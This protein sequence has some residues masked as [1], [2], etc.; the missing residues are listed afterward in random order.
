MSYVLWR[1]LL[2]ILTYFIA[3]VIFTL[4]HTP[5]LFFLDTV[6]QIASANFFMK[7]WFH[8]R[9]TERFAWFINNL[10][11]P[12]LQDFL[13]SW[14]TSLVWSDPILW[15]KW[16]ATI[17]LV[18]YL[19]TLFAFYKHFDL[20]GKII[21]T[22]FIGLFFFIQKPTLTYFQWLGYVDFITTGLLS[23]FLGAIRFLRLVYELLGKKRRRWISILLTLC[24]LSHL[25]MAPVA[26][27][28]IIVYTLLQK[29]RKLGVSL[30]IAVGVTSFFWLPLFFYREYLTSSNV[31]H[32]FPFVLILG[33]LFL[34]RHTKERKDLQ[35]IL[36]VAA[37]ILLLPELFL[38]SPH[39]ES[40]FPS[41]H[42]YRFG[43]IALL[44]SGIGFTFFAQKRFRVSLL[45]GYLLLGVMVYFFSR[46][47]SFVPLN[48][49]L[50]LSS[51]WST[52]DNQ[53][54]YTAVSL[55][56]QQ[57]TNNKRILVVDTHRPIDFNLWSYLQA[58]WDAHSF[59]QWLFRE[60]H[61]S[62]QLLSSYLATL[63]APY[64]IVNTYYY[65]Y[66]LKCE[67]RNKVFEKFVRDYALWWLISAPGE[68]IQY[69]DKINARCFQ[70][71]L[72]WWT[73]ALSV[74]DGGT[75]SI[76]NTE[77]TVRKIHV[78]TWALVER[79]NEYIELV[80]SPVVKKLSTDQE[81]YF[82]PLLTWFIEQV[83]KG[84][85]SSF[86]TFFTTTSPDIKM[87]VSNTLINSGESVS[88][89]KI[90]KSTDGSYTFFVPWETDRHILIKMSPLPGLHLVDEQENDIPRVDVFYGML[91]TWHGLIRLEFRSSA[92]F[93]YSKRLSI[94]FGIGF[95]LLISTWVIHSWVSSSL[96]SMKKKDWKKHGLF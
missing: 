58:Q 57:V 30:L 71:V 21:R 61:R 60:S 85:P 74:E 88:P 8:G 44:L 89:L 65:Y 25:V 47:F 72:S 59:V 79:S 69:M 45:E 82:S 14:V 78:R 40:V 1:F 52:S 43:S 33:T 49:L 5:N 41:F 46:T 94:A 34:L 27:A 16:Y 68:T 13:L 9:N 12:P 96:V 84:T 23:Q 80:D 2:G 95:I 55:L 56:R 11:Y 4:R 6:W 15:F 50:T 19:A 3:W 28:I 10:F 24:I 36:L 75:F 86:D 54:G 29:E 7:F 91:T 38:F 22:L 64:S 31:V 32:Y 62:N 66:G 90:D 83:S 20:R 53:E 48:T 42:Y 63:F 70:R 51:S 77:Y 35:A 93:L 67:T 18:A 26:F 37:G 17:L 81:Y 73:N 39:L 92:V 87:G 76:N